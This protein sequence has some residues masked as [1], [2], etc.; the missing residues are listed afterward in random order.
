MEKMEFGDCVKDLFTGFEGIYYAHCKFFT[1]CDRIGILP[2]EV[3]EGKTAE[4]EYFDI[5]RVKLVSKRAVVLPTNNDQEE[6]EKE[7]PGGLEVYF[8]HK[9]DPKN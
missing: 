3:R 6:G 2:M 7:K 5:Q 8:K 4:M 9:G 1:G